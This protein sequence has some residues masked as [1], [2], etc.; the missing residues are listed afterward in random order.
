MNKLALLLVLV[1]CDSAEKTAI[2]LLGSEADCISSSKQL[3][4]CTVGPNAYLCDTE[5]CKPVDARQAEK[6]MMLLDD[7][8]RQDDDDYQTQMQLTTT[9]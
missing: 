7:A 4:Y 3:A 1:A 6:I 8:K 2:R 5:K 9:Y